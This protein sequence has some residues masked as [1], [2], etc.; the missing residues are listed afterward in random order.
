MGQ[1]TAGYMISDLIHIFNKT[2][3]SLSIPLIGHHI[4]TCIALSLPH[5]IVLP[6]SLFL[7]ESSNIPN[8]SEIIANQ[9][10]G[11]LFDFNDDLKSTISNLQNQ[12]EIH[13][14][15]SKNALKTVIDKYSIDK[16]IEEEYKTYLS[17]I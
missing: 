10:N 13:D 16:I 12:S 4:L 1:V 5:N 6:F 17:V 3:A 14:S 8:N 7:A 2:S 9:V 15:I 11:Y